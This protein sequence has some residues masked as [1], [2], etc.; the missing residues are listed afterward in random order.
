MGFCILLSVFSQVSYL[1]GMA[2]MFFASV[3]ELPVFHGA[4][5]TGSST[6]WLDLEPDCPSFPCPSFVNYTSLHQAPLSLHLTTSSLSLGVTSAAL[7]SFVSCHI[8]A[9]S[10]PL[11]NPQVLS[12]PSPPVFQT[13]RL[14]FH[15]AYLLFFFVDH[16]LISCFLLLQCGQHVLVIACRWSGIEHPI[17]QYTVFCKGF[18]FSISLVFFHFICGHQ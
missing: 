8:G 9:F 12:C 6:D 16:V 15:C 17:K 5:S 14:L 3:Q 2:D 7:P 11:S 1:H 4:L 18:S 13:C 10:G